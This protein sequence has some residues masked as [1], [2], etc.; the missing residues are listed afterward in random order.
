VGAGPAHVAVHRGARGHGAAVLL[1]RRERPARQLGDLAP[2]DRRLGV[3]AAADRVDADLLPRRVAG[4]LVVVVP[5]VVVHVRRGVADEED[6]LHRPVGPPHL[7]Y[8]LVQRPA[9]LLGPVA[10]ALVAGPAQ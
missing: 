7:G 2:G 10:A 4:N 9:Y 5:V 8:R 3:V 6:E 1:D